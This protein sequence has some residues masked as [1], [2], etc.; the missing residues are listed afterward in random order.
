M[1]QAVTVAP[2]LKKLSLKERERRNQSNNYKPSEKKTFKKELEE[3]YCRSTPENPP[4]YICGYTKDA[5]PVYSPIN[6]KEYA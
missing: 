4:V 6:M 2:E 3:A 1:V 5:L